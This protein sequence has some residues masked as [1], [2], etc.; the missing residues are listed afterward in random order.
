MVRE[1]S[2]VAERKITRQS[3]IAIVGAGLSGATIARVLREH[4][5]TNLTVYEALDHVAGNAYTERCPMTDVMLHKYGPH[6]FHTDDAEVWHWFD[7]FAKLQPYIQRT[8]AVAYG[9]TYSFPINLHTLNQFWREDF[10][11]DEAKAKLA[12]ITGDP[13]DPTN[14]ATYARSLVGVQLYRA[15]IEG[16]TRKAWGR[17][18][19]DLP[20][21][22]IKRLPLR[23]TYDDNVF[24]HKYQGMPRSGYTV[25]V[26]RMLDG[27]KVKRGLKFTRSA[28]NEFDH[29]FYTGPLD[30]WFRYEHGMLA[31]R[32]LDF[33]HSVYPDRDVMQGCS[34]LNNCDFTTPWTRRT[35]HKFF[36]PWDPAH[37]TVVTEETPREWVEGDV[38]YYPVRLAQDKASLAQYE[39]R[40]KAEPNVSFVG[41]L[42][43]YRYLDMDQCIREAMD[44]ARKFAGAAG[45]ISVTGI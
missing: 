35:E 42:A 6:I 21:S 38:R 7:R 17:D 25:A 44:A 24:F 29:V 20:A 36:T 30:E 45:V 4:G 12:Q 28:A 5:F 33:K 34:V 31:Y 37:G 27:V 13:L 2:G 41:R 8:K 10:T 1:K 26:E 18:P 39:E 16:Y 40:A 19:A 43:T 22:I 23:F 15:F 11:P 3:K 14:F 9:E 32:T